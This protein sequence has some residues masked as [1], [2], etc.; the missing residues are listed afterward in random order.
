MADHKV[1]ITWSGVIT[2]TDE[3]LADGSY[4]ESGIDAVTIDEACVNETRWV[5]EGASSA[6]ELLDCAEDRYF[7]VVPVTDVLGE[8]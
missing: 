2:I 6:A 5:D 1:R 4:S 3:Q 7:S 8:G